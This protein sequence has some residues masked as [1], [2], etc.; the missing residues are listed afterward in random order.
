MGVASS[1]KMMKIDS[2][3][4]R[5]LG[6]FVLKPGKPGKRTKKRGKVEVV[7]SFRSAQ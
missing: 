3:R 4:E 7:P 1:E 2:P 6:K 5:E